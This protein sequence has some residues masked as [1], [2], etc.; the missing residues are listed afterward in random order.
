MH[1][2]LLMMLLSEAISELKSTPAGPLYAMLMS[3]IS[4]G[5][6]QSFIE[7]FTKL[8]LVTKKGDMLTWHDPVE[9]TDG[10]KLIQG[11][12][13]AKLVL[14]TQER[15]APKFCGECAKTGVPIPSREHCTH[16]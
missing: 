10:F 9:G 8:G 15:M 14:D 1:K 5:D 6:F 13:R 3:K 16:A 2:L 12:K 4:L 7:V 11:F